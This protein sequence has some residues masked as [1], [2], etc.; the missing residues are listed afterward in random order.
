MTAL[1]VP[2]DPQ[3]SKREMPNHINVECDE[4]SR[5][6]FIGR[7]DDVQEFTEGSG[8]LPHERAIRNLSWRGF[9]TPQLVVEEHRSSG[10]L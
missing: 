2:N 10:S 3:R 8:S 5:S 9:S 1:R 6:A 7:L 4:T